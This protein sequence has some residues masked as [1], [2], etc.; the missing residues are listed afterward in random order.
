MSLTTHGSI[1]ILLRGTKLLTPEGG[2]VT[3][4]AAVGRKVQ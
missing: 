1:V 3:D 2:G 4:I